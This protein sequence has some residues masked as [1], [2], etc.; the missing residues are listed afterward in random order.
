MLSFYLPGVGFWLRLPI[1]VFIMVPGI[2][3]LTA[4]G[5]PATG[6]LSGDWQAQEIEREMRKHYR[7]KNSASAS[8]RIIRNGN[9]E[10]ERTGTPATEVGSGGGFC[11]R[12]ER[13]DGSVTL[14]YSTISRNNFSS[15]ASK[16][17]E[18]PA[19]GREV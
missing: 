4:F 7:Q 19:C 1:P 15:V 3:Y 17:V 8:G 14:I 12:T 10:I 9:T 11:G 13:V 2:L 6:A 5:L 18:K 16:S